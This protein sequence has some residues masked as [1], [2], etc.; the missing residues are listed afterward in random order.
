MEPRNRSYNEAM[1]CA[2]FPRGWDLEPAGIEAFKTPD[3]E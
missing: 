2:T 3:D 1:K